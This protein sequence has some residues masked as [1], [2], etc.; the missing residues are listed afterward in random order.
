[1]PISKDDYEAMD[2]VIAGFNKQERIKEKGSGRRR[3]SRPAL[4]VLIDHRPSGNVWEFSK[5]ACLSQPVSW[6][7]RR[8]ALSVVRGDEP[9][10]PGKRNLITALIGLQRVADRRG[11]RGTRFRALVLQGAACGSE[12]HRGLE[13]LFDPASTSNVEIKVARL[14]YN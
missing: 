10:R 9:D 6:T 12:C 4:N 7:F 1:M 3:G 14:K 5:C 8:H 2:M 11:N 13:S